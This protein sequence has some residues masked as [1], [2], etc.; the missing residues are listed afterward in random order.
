MSDIEEASDDK[1]IELFRAELAKA[2]EYMMSD[3]KAE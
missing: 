2:Y 1:A 3:S